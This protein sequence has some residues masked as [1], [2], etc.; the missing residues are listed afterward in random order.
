M[1]LEQYGLDKGM[2]YNS[3]V[4]PDPHHF[5]NLDPDPHLH[6]IKIRIRIMIMW[7]HNT[8]ILCT[9]CL[10]LPLTP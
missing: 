2:V 5:G 9:C 3:V 10:S 6:R 1:V 8:G 7:I 4:D